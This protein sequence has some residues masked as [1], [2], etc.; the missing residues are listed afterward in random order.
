MLACYLQK[1]L[2]SISVSSL[3]KL[4]KCREIGGMFKVIL[5]DI[6]DINFSL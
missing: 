3:E 6:T 2:V 1:S 5:T 4:C